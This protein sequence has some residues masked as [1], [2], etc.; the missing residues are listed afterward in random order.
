MILSIGGLFYLLL[1][2]F[3]SGENVRVR[4]LT[5]YTIAI[6]KGVSGHSA[7]SAPK[8][9]IV[10]SFKEIVRL[11]TQQ[12]L[13]LISNYHSGTNNF[14]CVWAPRTYNGK[15]REPLSGVDREMNMC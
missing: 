15:D 5:L 7:G 8:A 11:T 2:N 1:R 6:Q 12:N 13:D 10:F 14:V 3:Q 9:R 4:L